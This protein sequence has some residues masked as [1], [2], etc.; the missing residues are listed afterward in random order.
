MIDDF[1]CLICGKPMTSFFGMGAH[2]YQHRK[3]GQVT[4]RGKR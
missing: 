1:D 2:V 4:E 3:K